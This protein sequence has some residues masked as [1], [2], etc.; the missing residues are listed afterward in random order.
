M[1]P[2]NLRCCA[3]GLGN[4]K[5]PQGIGSNSALRRQ[6]RWQTDR[7]R[8]VIDVQYQVQTR[9]VS[10]GNLLGAPSSIH[11]HYE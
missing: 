7:N 10:D 8:C 2:G 1:P 9:H 6:Q 4:T 3:Y 11:L 5:G